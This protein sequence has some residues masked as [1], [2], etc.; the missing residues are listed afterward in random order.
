MWPFFREIVLVD[1]EFEALQGER[2]NPVCLVAWELRSGR[3]FRIWKDQFG[4]A[5][6]YATGPDVLFAAYYASAELGCYRALGWRP[7]ERILD[8]FIEFRNRT[9]GLGTPAGAGLLGALTYFGLDSIGA[10][11]KKE[12]QK[13][14]GAGT[15]HGHFTN[16]EILDYC[17]QDV[18][19]VQRLLLVMAPLIDMPRAL[20]RGRYM[21]AAAAMEHNGVPIDTVTL[22]LLQQNWTA[23]QDQLIA[24]IDTD[25]HVFEGCTFKH[26]RFDQFLAEH[27]IPWPRHESGSLD[28][29]DG[30]FRQMAKAHPQISPL[31]ELRSALSELRLNDL[32]VGKDGR[33][34]VILSAFRSRSGRNQPSNSKFIFGPSVW[35]RGLIQPPPGHGVVYVDWSQQ[36][37]GIAAALSGDTA[38]QEA[39]RSGDPYLTFAKQA[40]AVPAVATKNSHRAEREL[41]KQC[42]LGVQ[43]GMEDK[44]LAARIGQPTIVARE[45]L[46]AH[47]ET[48]RRFWAWSDAALDHAML[49]GSLHT[50]FGWY[51]HVGESANPRSLRNFPMQANGAE[52]L[53]LACCLAVERGVEICAPVHDAV[54]ISA[55]EER[56]EIDIRT[57]RDAMAE[58]SRTV[59]NG[60]ELSTDV[61]ITR[62]PDRYMDERGTVMWERV[63][64]LI[65]ERS[66]RERLIA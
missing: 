20:L 55:P 1:F 8:L 31:R 35:L 37:F 5:P 56:L 42:V 38:M 61:K 33:N 66:H 16:Q 43:Y 53:R 65:G 47:R 29:G 44:S 11:E 36:E 9:N 64:K 58:A 12:L 13:C 18:A 3:K 41:F 22:E 48:Y 50:V 57:T 60:F 54:L 26:N 23:I 30:T 7:P 59:L 25:Y 32:S 15:W 34:R 52:M 2:P 28:L 45:L 19:A 17:E 10:S 27:R 46:R 6:P 40:K 51:V 62:W 21:M 4:P 39:Y 14:I 63:M 49:N 24:E